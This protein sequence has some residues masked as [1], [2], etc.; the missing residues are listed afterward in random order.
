MITI[1]R[2]WVHASQPGYIHYIATLP[3]G[4]RRRLYAQREG[5]PGNI[6]LYDLLESMLPQA[7]RS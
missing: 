6:A 7:A 3:D 5:G 1:G 2:P 4:T